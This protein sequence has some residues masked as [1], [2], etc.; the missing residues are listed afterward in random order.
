M[1][2]AC[3][4][5]ICLPGLS[6]VAMAVQENTLEGHAWQGPARVVQYLCAQLLPVCCSQCT[7]SLW[8]GLCVA[9]PVWW[10]STSWSDVKL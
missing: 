1:R 3:C 2:T 4:T 10:P 5:V 9:A 7:L 6:H 8:N